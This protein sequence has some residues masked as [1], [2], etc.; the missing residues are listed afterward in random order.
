MNIRSP[1][2]FLISFDR[3][4]TTIKYKDGF[5][6]KMPKH[7]DHLHAV[8]DISAQKEKIVENTLRKSKKM[9]N[10]VPASE[11]PQTIQHTY[12]LVFRDTVRNCM[13]MRRDAATR[14]RRQRLFVLCTPARALAA[15]RMPRPVRDLEYP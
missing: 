11:T 3:Q 7:A 10:L 14:R 13:H 9:P 4:I 6:T 5:H 2:R 8:S 1:R 15:S 12:P